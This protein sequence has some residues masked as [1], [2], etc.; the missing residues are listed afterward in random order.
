MNPRRVAALTRRI[1]AQF[2]RDRRTLALLFIAPIAIIGLL[3]W[4]LRDQ[5]APVTRVVFVNGDGAVGNA[6][7][8]R[9]EPLLTAQGLTVLP[10]AD[11]ATARSLLA[12]DNADLAVELPPGFAASLARGSQPDL[13]VVTAGLNPTTEGSHL[14]AFQKAL[15][16]ALGQLAPNLASRT[17]QITHATVYGSANADEVD[18]LAPVFVGFFAYFFVFIL[19]GISFLRERVGG[20]LERLLA[21]PITRGEIVVGYSLGFA[22]FASIQVALVLLFTL[23]TL[24]VPAIGP[25]PDFWI[26]LGVPSAGNT[27]LAYLVALLLGLGAVSL[28]IFLSTFARTEFQ[29][30]QFIPIVIVP[31]GLLSG[32]FWPIESLPNLLQPIARVLP[33]TYA[34]EGLRRVL[35]AGDG[36]ASSTVQLDLVVLAAIAGVFV[37]LAAGTIRREVA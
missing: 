32:F 18:V 13:T 6:L 34:V 5:Q 4:V 2:R 17:P 1:V 8:S 27:L 28:G 35:I 29:I 22:I 26:G 19:T 25:L 10:P 12:D 7:L 31:Q 20:T 37:L 23:G 33:V 9:A 24:H 3:G 21:T 36:L 16:S 14:L 11:D 15:A 30:L